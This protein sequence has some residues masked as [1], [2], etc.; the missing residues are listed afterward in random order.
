MEGIIYL[1]PEGKHS[2]SVIHGGEISHGRTTIACSISQGSELKYRCG[3]K[4]ACSC[5]SLTNSIC[6]VKDEL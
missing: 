1:Y 3:I 5:G 2:A 4:E 6:N